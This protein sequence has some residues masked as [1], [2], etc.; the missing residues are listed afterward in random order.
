MAL[1]QEFVAITTGAGVENLKKPKYTCCPRS[2]KPR[3]LISS[4]ASFE[5]FD[6]LPCS[7]SPDNGV[8]L[9]S[10][11]VS[12]HTSGIIFVVRFRKSLCRTYTK[13]PLL[14]LILY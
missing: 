1:L 6:V 2:L 9:G 10:I 5:L 14:Q 3:V 4:L 13:P 12:L 7:S 11:S 8:I